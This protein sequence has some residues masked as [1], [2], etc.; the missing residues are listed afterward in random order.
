MIIMYDAGHG[1]R[2][3]GAETSILREADVNLAVVLMMEKITKELHPDWDLLL[4]R[5]TD[6]YISPGARKRLCLSKKPNAFISIHCN[7]A[8]SAKAN[9]FEVVYRDQP[10]YNLGIM[11]EETF[12][13]AFNTVKK[14][15]LKNDL[16]D[17]GRE[18]AVLS[19]PGIASVIVELGFI[20][21]PLDKVILQDTLGL[22]SVL[23][24]GV[25]RWV[26]VFGG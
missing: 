23:V 17:L 20:T 3:P 10:S 13:Q 14:R 21:N 25:E 2:D 9:G 26:E 1:G 6:T 11:I 4:T 19:T 22:A 12:L 15:G 8:E 18:L 16:K 7:A 24:K 5:N